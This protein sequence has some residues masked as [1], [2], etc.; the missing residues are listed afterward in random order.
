[1]LD[2]VFR[3]SLR[4]NVEI[5]PV[6]FSDDSCLSDD[7]LVKAVLDGNQTA[8]EQ[9]FTKHKRSVTGTVARFFRERSDIE[10]FVQES[11]AKA[12]FSLKKYRGGG[13]RS[14]AAWITRIAINVCYDEFRRRTRRGENGQVLLDDDEQSYI[15]TIADGRS[16]SPESRVLAAQLAEKLLDAISPEDRIALIMVYSDECTLDEAATAIGITTS[17]LK[18]RL[19]RCRKHLRKRFG[20]IFK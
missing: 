15:E 6:E 8:F 13:D 18:S 10:E 9:L 4:T 20:H 12:Y 5:L 17:S 19:F 2:E 7:Y 11:F 14:F 1:M 3:I 16:S